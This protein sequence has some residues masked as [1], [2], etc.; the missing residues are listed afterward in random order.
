MAPQSSSSLR[1]KSCSPVTSATLSRSITC[2]AATTL[3]A[4]PRRADRQHAAEVFW[5]RESNGRRDSSSAGE[6]GQV[7]SIRIDR[8]L[9][10]HVVE[11]IEHDP[12]WPSQW[13]I[14][15]GIVSAGKDDS[16]T[17]AQFLELLPTGRFCS[18]AEINST[19]EAGF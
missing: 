9:P 5:Q 1:L 6:A 11:H 13:T 8:I 15:A 4:N 7:G 19:S 2:C 3:H 17:L 14:V 12:H 16:H 10:S 18:R